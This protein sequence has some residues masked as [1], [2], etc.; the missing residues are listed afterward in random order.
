MTLLRI[1]R[2]WVAAMRSE[3]H[4]VSPWRAAS[5]VAKQALYVWHS[6][7]F[8]E[9]HWWRTRMRACMRCSLYRRATHQCGSAAWAFPDRTG[10]VW[11][12]QGCGCAMPLKNLFRGTVCWARETGKD[13]LPGVGWPED[14]V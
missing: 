14:V 3:G 9:P 12:R 10:G 7:P 13:C 6:R 5:M 2:L 8:V 4:F 11:F 1:F